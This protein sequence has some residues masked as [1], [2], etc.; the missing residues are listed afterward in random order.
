MFGLLV[1][2][3]LAGVLKADAQPVTTIYSFMEGPANPRAGLTLGNDGNFYGTTEYGGGG[4]GTLFKLTTNG[5]MTILVNFNGYGNG[6]LPV[7]NLLLGPDGNFYGTTLDGGTN[8]TGTNA[9]GTVFKMT[10]N[11][12][13]TTLVNFNGLNGGIPVAGLALGADG[14]FYGTT[15]FGGLYAD[16]MVFKMTTNGTL[17]TLVNFN[18]T[19][20]A[21]PLASLTL[22]PGG[23]LYGTTRYGGTNGSWGTVFQVTTNGTF[24]TLLPFAGTNGAW[25]YGGVT[26]GPDGNLY[27]TT[28]E[29]FY[30]NNA[31]TGGNIFELTTNGVLTTLVRLA[32]LGGSNGVTPYAGL[33]LGPDGNFYGTTYAGGA[34]GNGTVFQVSTNGT[35]AML[36]Q[37]GI[38]FQAYFG[39]FGVEYYSTNGGTNIAEVFNGTLTTLHSFSALTNGLNPDGAQPQASLTLGPDG[40]FY[41][42]AYGGGAT[43]YGTVFKVSTNGIFSTVASFTGDTGVNPESTLTPGPNG[44][45]YGTAKFGGI[46]G[47]GTLF[48]LTTSGA[49]TMLVNFDSANDGANPQAG[50]I[51]GP[52]GNFYGT[53]VGGGT[54]LLDLGGNNFDVLSDGTVFGLTTNG[55]LTPLV[56]FNGTNGA[57]PYGG[58]AVGADGNLYG[59]T[60]YGGISNDGTIF[61]ITTNGTL[62]TLTNFNGLNGAN[63]QASLTLGPDGNFY[64]TCGAGGLNGDGTV[65]QVTTNGALTTLAYFNGT[66]GA[67]PQAG[68]LL[69]LDG[70]FYGTTYEGGGRNDGTV[71]K[72]TTSGTLTTLVNFA[73]TN[74]EFPLAELALG[75]DGNFYGT[76]LLGGVGNAGTVFK[77]ATNGTLTTV[78]NFNFNDGEGLFGGLT[79][80]T[81]SHFIHFYSTTYG[82]GS[83][84]AG[85]VFQLNLTTAYTMT[86]NTTNTFYPLT[87]EVV[88]ATGGTLGL[89]SAGATNGTAQI[90]GTGIVF[91]PRTNFTG[92][93]TINYAVT[94]NAGGTNASFITILVTNIPPVANPDFY[95]VAENSSANVL[96]PLTNDLLGTSGGVLGLVSV[97]PTNGTAVI[98]GTN[99]LFT[100]SLNFMGTATIGYTITDKIGG[101]NTSLITVSVVSADADVSLSGVTS[102]GPVTLEGNLIYTITVSNAGPQTA[103]GMIVSNQLPA[104]ATFFSA[105]VQTNFSG[106]GTSANY[107]DFFF[108]TNGVLLMN[109]GS[110]APGNRTLFTV[111]L[112]PTAVGQITNVFQVLAD[113]NDPMPTNNSLNT[114][115]IIT[116]PPPTGIPGTPYNGAWENIVVA[117]EATIYVAENVGS[118]VQPFAVD[119]LPTSYA[120]PGDFVMLLNP[121]GGNNPTNWV[122]VARFFNPADPTGTNGLPATMQSAFFPT[123][124][125]AAGFANFKLLPNVYFSTSLSSGPGDFSAVYTVIGP[126]AG[127]N[128]GN[129][130]II[131][132]TVTNGNADLSLTATASPEP[133]GVDSNLVY[134]LTVSNAGP[135]AASGVTISNLVPAGVTFVSAP[136]GATPTNGVLLVNLGSL[137]EG[138]NASV[139]IVVQATAAANLTNF[140]Q[141]FAN[142]IDP[143]LTNNFATVISTVTNAPVSGAD[144]SLSA[145]GPAYTE[146]LGDTLVYNLLVTNRGPDTATGLVISN[147]IPVGVTFVSVYGNSA[148]PNNGV[149]LVSLGS[150]PVGSTYS[151]QITVQPN[152]AGMLTNAFQVFANETDPVL[153]NNFATVITPVM[154]AAAIAGIPGNPLTWSSQN[155]SPILVQEGAGTG[156]NPI[157]LISS[158]IPYPSDMTT[159]PG[160]VVFLTDPNGGTNTS[161]WTA[162]LNF[163]NPGD[164]NG[165]VGLA[166]TK[167]QT[168]FPTNA[169]PNAFANFPLFPNVIY[170]P[171][172]V[173]NA[174]GSITATTN[175]LGPIAG[176]ATN[177]QVILHYT[178]SIQ[179]TLFPPGTNTDLGLI[180][181]T[182]DVTGPGPVSILERLVYLITV[183]NLGPQTASDVVISNRL[184]ANVNFISAN[185]V[186]NTGIVTKNVPTNGVLLVNLGLLDSGAV[187]TFHIVVQPT[188]PG[189]ITNVFRLF[190]DQTDPVPANNQVT[191]VSAVTN[192]PPPGIPGTPYAGIWNP[193]VPLN[194]NGVGGETIFENANVTSAVQTI[195][196]S[197]SADG[198]GNYPSNAIPGDFVILLDPNGGT[199]TSNWGAVARFF[200]PGDPTGT[201]GWAATQD[202][203]FFPTDFGAAGFAH[204]KLFPN[205][206]FFTG[207]VLADSPAP[208]DFFTVRTEVGPDVSLYGGQVDIFSLSAVNTAA[209]LSL[210]ATATPEPV[211]VGSNLVYSLT[212][213]NAGPADATDVII[214]NRLPAGVNFVSATGGATPTNGVLLLNLGSLAEGTNTSVQVI[215]QPTAAGNLTNFFQVFANEIDPVLTNNF[216]TVISTV[217]NAA[218]TGTTFTTSTA[219]FDTNYTATASQQVT[220]YST[221]LIA[222]L[223]NGTVVYDQTFNLAYPNTTVQAAITTAAG[224]LTGAGAASYTGPTQT[225]FSQNLTN[226][227]SVTVTNRT[228]TNVIAGTKAFIGPVTISVGNFGVVQDYTFDPVVTTYAIPIGGNPQS[229]TVSA[230]GIDYD[231]MLLSI[232]TNNVTTTAT[233]TYLN[234]AVYVM[235]GIVSQVDVALSLMTAPNPVAVGA[236][237][238]YSLTVTNNSTT[239]ATGVVVS[240]TLPP[241]VTV[242]SLLPSEGSATN[243][244]GVVTYS[245]GNLPNGDAATLAIVVIPEAAGLLTNVA[246]AFSAQPDS[247]PTNNRA[248]NVTSA[249]S[250]PITNLVL[251]VLSPITLNP[252]TGL[253]EQQVEVSNGGPSTP[254]SVLVLVSGLAGNATLYNATGKTNGL[255]FVQSA[256]PLGIGSNVVFLL[257][258]YV[259][260]RVAPTNL[261]FTV[262]AGPPFIPPVVSGTIMNIDRMI[263]LSDGSVLVE[264]T[265][266]P[267]Q[268][269]AIQYSSNMVT[270]R[271]AV[272]AITAPANKVQWIDSGPPKT[273][274]NPAQQPAR[275]YRVVLLTAH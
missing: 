84:G 190:A 15:E 189:R 242:F 212:F 153:T 130:G 253:F 251:T 8:I 225:S 127:F 228:G 139:Q 229:F 11:G 106:T 129:I 71:F 107:G 161:N 88:W 191:T 29:G 232:V 220:N 217:T 90:T 275:Y 160:D 119:G 120:I 218:S 23:N 170:V 109:L 206:T 176:V 89:V 149:L 80:Q 205:V 101:T 215:V 131:A 173:T 241:D 202:R 91:T 259:P 74:G 185:V 21:N 231:T 135:N 234:S 69:G 73:Q 145:S 138:T 50:L 43:G 64:G 125:G 227:S 169:G 270:W 123:D 16:G 265:A 175:I 48:K 63:S 140:F 126:I 181:S 83:S 111:F 77:L 103:T 124:F 197:Y 257:E 166:A 258:F 146:V 6:S 59:T 115:A 66:N 40:N 213:S 61:Q 204:F 49:L 35:L 57:N 108:P 132:L 92:T 216:A 263:V 41:G 87:N 164:T 118:G 264:F 201:N 54:N 168:Y 30:P 271:T 45:L 110:L 248:T 56:D 114:V 9:T 219:E 137:A 36:A 26:V 151:G 150:L 95:S 179:P 1:W 62:T 55:I 267:G 274:S 230:G 75:P 245:V 273:D 163:F 255:P 249:V 79:L 94:D 221:E 193:L 196:A 22:G 188:L 19:N 235:T 27:G 200:D 53:A 236:P 194:T 158:Q 182:P 141:V 147:R 25:P 180:V 159:L 37:A 174:D 104:N 31:T 51:P 203:A 20:G 68:L 211:G 246:I 133:V 100:P 156:V 65:F 117:D 3:A 24:T 152:V 113:E 82:G 18:G 199:N 70:N 134:S 128:G 142:E 148:T 272:P 268:V 252:Q 58:L 76:T 155:L 184:P 46:G 112:Q 165:T 192:A 72:I 85:T 136:G 183:T 247:Q 13:L 5:I 39:G 10:T 60:T 93:A 44:S 67:D 116:N 38:P 154:T 162:V 98:S 17:T 237:L 86:E 187:K 34:N 208:G 96:N 226:A 244:A 2:V 102:L 256:S 260:T 243:N 222:R 105:Y 143:V 178:A 171:I 28:S 122:A 195:Q 78:A 7:A 32:D 172:A 250:V 42:T 223:P 47:R 266:I 177:Q 239:T 81:N 198:D 167:Y 33:T 254:S 144:L 210:S 240:N 214:S 97:S 99:V 238:T 207:T 262:V 209:D 12:T 14:N 121:T 224:D 233:N 157:Y 52:G 4:E 186:T 261:T 269:Y